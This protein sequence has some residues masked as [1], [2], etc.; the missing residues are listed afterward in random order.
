M[1]LLTIAY[2]PAQA[3]SERIG[4]RDPE[5]VAEGPS[6]SAG[7]CMGY[8]GSGLAPKK[9]RKN[10]AADGHVGLGF[11]KCIRGFVDFFGG[12][13]LGGFYC[14]SDVSTCVA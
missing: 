13:S 7:A 9:A 14:A 2:I 4:E 5:P 10:K 8:R 1:H 3:R 12:P 6:R 11:R